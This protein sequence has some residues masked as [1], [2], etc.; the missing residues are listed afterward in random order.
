MDPRAGSTH[1]PCPAGAAVWQKCHPRER[2]LEWE[3]ERGGLPRERG[4]SPRGGKSHP[5]EAMGTLTAVGPKEP[6][7]NRNKGT[8]WVQGARERSHLRRYR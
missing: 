7:S 4:H 1:G 5:D 2:P 3:V 6:T 8:F